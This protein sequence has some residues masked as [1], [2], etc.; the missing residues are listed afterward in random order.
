MAAKK[1]A[2][3]CD[4]DPTEAV[5]HLVDVSER[6]RCM[7]MDRADALVGCTERSPEEAELAAIT[8]VIEAYGQARELASWP[9]EVKRQP[10][11]GN[12]D[13]G[14]HERRAAGLGISESW[15]RLMRVEHAAAYCGEKSVSAFRRAVGAL[16]PCPLRVPGKGERWL[17]EALDQAID[18]LAGK[19]DGDRPLSER[20]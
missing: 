2:A 6:M 5:S 14:P 13:I 17:K 4:A 18:K 1:K 11:I 15:P 19:G 16:Y 3:A 8:E 20:L 9:H 12:D 10:S 7:L